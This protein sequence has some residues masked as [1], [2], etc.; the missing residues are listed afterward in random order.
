[1]SNS[2]TC[3]VILAGHRTG[4]SALAGLIKR[5]GVFMGHKFVGKTQYNQRGHYEDVEFLK[6]HKRIIGNWKRPCVDFEPFRKKY[7]LLVRQRERN[8]PLWGFKDPRFCYVFPYFQ[9]IT[10]ARLVV[11]ALHRNIQAT[12]Q[13][14]MARRG[15]SA[16]NVTSPQAGKIARFYRD[17]QWLALRCYE[18]AV[19]AVQYETLI[20]RPGTEVTR[21]AEFVGVP[22]N[23][24]AIQFIDKS[25]KH[26]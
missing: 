12:K 11:I 6:L 26:H 13:S 4:S 15:R 17:A 25:L 23:E 22:V 1:M 24:S 8:H 19:L 18:G 3:V 16:I 14:L 9:R 21:I 2:S 7:T 10:K 20:K 5:L